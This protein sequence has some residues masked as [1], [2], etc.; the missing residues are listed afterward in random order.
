MASRKDSFGAVCKRRPVLVLVTFLVGMAFG[1]V[2]AVHS[3]NSLIWLCM[4]MIV[5]GALLGLAED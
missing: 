4:G 3:L 2:I 1:M 5:D